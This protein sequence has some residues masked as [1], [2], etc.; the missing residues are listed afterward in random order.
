MMEG[1]W[2]ERNPLTNSHFTAL[3][4]VAVLAA[5]VLLGE[6]T[7]G[8]TPTEDDAAEIVSVSSEEDPVKLVSAAIVTYTSNIPMYVFHSSAGVRGDE[9]LYDMAGVGAFVHLEAFVPGD[10][11][12]WTRKNAHWGTSPFCVFAEDSDGHFHPDLMWVD[13]HDPVS[14][15][16]RAYGDVKGN[17]FFVIPFGILNRVVME[18]RDDMDFDVIDPM[19]G[20][21]VSS[22]SLNEGE[23]FELSGGQAFV[24]KGY[25]R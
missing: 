17:E 7:C 15:A 3:L 10:L 12:S 16:V 8:E 4:C 24:I 18:P 1:T 2:K 5:P 9:E 23:R 22:W 14:G 25:F 21:I 13:L 6:S 20:G 11:A 19:T